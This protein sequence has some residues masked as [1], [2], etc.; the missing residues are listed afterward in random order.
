MLTDLRFH[1]PETIEEATQLLDRLKGAR[2]M[3][4]GTDL[5]VDAKQG[6][7]DVSDVVSLHRIREL[8]G[9][10]KE[11]DAIRIGALVT[12]EELASDPLIARY[13]PAV[14]DAARSMASRQIRSVATVGGNIASAVPSADLPPSLIA[15]GASVKLRCSRSTRELPLL[16]FF[17]G[18]RETVCRSAELVTSVSVPLPSP[19]T[20]IS[21]QKFALREASA[22]A[23]AA[24]ASALTL[25][26]GTIQKAAIVLGAVAPTPLAAS[27]ASDLLTRKEPTGELFEEAASLAKEEAKPISDIRGSV[28]HRRELVGVLTKRTL[29]EALR[30]AQGQ[31]GAETRRGD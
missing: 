28:W 2:V 9:I 8:K 21:Y 25:E 31:Q 5:I 11:G 17:T 13:L 16:E 10:D 15:A 27:K 30:R 29:A 20:G 7:T 12:A 26:K 19:G 22:L 4:G 14:A 1:S 18:P 6:L 24:V 3:A 23:V